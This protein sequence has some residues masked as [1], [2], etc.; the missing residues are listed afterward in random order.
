MT[1]FDFVL[2]LPIVVGGGGQ[3][4][5]FRWISNKSTN[6]IALGFFSLSKRVSTSITHTRFFDALAAS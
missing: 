1:S 6:D 2:Q 5:F 4:C 3:L